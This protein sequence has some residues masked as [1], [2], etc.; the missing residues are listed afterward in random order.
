MRATL[1]LGNEWPWTGGMAQYLRW[2]EAN[3]IYPA[4]NCTSVLS[5]EAPDMR[6]SSWLQHGW[7]NLSYPGPGH[8]APG[9]GWGEWQQLV[10]GF[11]DSSAAQELWRAHVTFLLSRRSRY[12][13][14]SVGDDPT[15]AFLELANE[16]R[17]ANA[18]ASPQFNQWL[19][20][21]AQL[22]KKLAP[23]TLITSGMEGDTSHINLGQATLLSQASVAGIDVLT[24]ARKLLPLHQNCLT[25]TQ[26]TCGR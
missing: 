10:G 22:L 7:Q 8:P 6:D 9:G 24:G 20:A 18:S 2:A 12:T 23:R 16:P 19:A 1:V 14:V 3:Y 13:G 15:V 26:F 25:L 5:G 17:P 4:A 21:S 11:Y